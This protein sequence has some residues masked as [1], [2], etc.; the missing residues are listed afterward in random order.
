VAGQRALT[1]RRASSHTS[2][3]PGGRLYSRIGDNQLAKTYLDEVFVFAITDS[4]DR[5][6]RFAR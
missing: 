5:I 3:A 6:N 4:P 1:R 2:P